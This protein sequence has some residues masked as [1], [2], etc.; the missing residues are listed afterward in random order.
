M[1]RLEHDSGPGAAALLLALLLVPAGL[2]AQEPSPMREHDPEMMARHQEMMAHHEQMMA[3]MDS[4][5]VAM[6]ESTGDA[7]VDAMAALLNEIVEQHRA[8]HEHMGEMMMHRM[9]GGGHGEKMK[10]TPP[11]EDTTEEAAEHEHPDEPD[12]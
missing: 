1:R 9:M 2:H 3:R 8:M 4:L 7:K 12:N 6:N 10:G 5:A 11:G